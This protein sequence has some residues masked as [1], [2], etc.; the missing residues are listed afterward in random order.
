MEFEGKIVL[1]LQMFAEG[2]DG[3]EGD[4]AEQGVAAA[5]PAA[6]G[7][8]AT[9]AATESTAETGAQSP[10]EQ[11]QSWQ[12]IKKA[13]KQDYNAEV[14]RIVQDRLRGANEYRSKAEQAFAIMAQKYGGDPGDIDGLIR[15]M[16]DDNSFY[17]DE[18]LER[19]LTVDQLK[20]I[21]KLERENATL[22]QMREQQQLNEGAARVYQ[23]WM[24]ASDVIRKTYNPAF[25]LDEE[26]SNNPEFG[27]LIKANV[28]LQTAYEVCHR[29]ELAAQ[30]M[31]V[32]ARKTE[33]AVVNKIKANGMRPSE[34]GLGDAQAVNLNVDPR[35]LTKEQRAEI[36]KRV[37]RGEKVVF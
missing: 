13:Y 14:S 24:Q 6:G 23:T 32:A 20:E 15:N 3:G 25:D 19:G 16:E 34:A 22:R 27:R 18:A 29:D 31:R 7:P 1:D 5:S 12:D 37:R 21:K 2:A 36:K 8:A 11:R 10:Q 28:P 26:I 9:G 30:A 17:E 35:N 33:E 4:G